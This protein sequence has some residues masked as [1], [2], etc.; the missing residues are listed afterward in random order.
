MEKWTV[1]PQQLR[2]TH[3]HKT[4][5]ESKED[6]YQTYHIIERLTC[7]PSRCLKEIP[8]AKKEAFSQVPPSFI[9][10]LPRLI[11]SSPSNS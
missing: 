6:S 11:S 2:P 5:P 3:S 9:L 4:K 1:I 7:I 10:I 8:Q